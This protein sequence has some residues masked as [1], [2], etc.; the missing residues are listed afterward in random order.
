M[1][2]AALARQILRVVLDRAQAV[3]ARQVVR[4]RGWVAETERLSPESLCLHFQ[5]AAGGPAAAAALEFS[6]IAITARCR[7]CGMKFTPDHHLVLCPRCGAADDA[8]LSH[9][10]GYAI[11]SLEV[12]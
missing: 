3:H 2:E 5:A 7:Q 9:P 10:A 6:V 4:V 11:D 1:H 8:A 12:R